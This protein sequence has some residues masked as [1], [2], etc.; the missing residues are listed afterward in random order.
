[1]TASGIV[2]VVFLIYL[3]FVLTV[4]IVTSRRNRSLDT[5][6]LGGRK[7]GPWM[8]AISSTASSESAWVT[9]GTVGLA[10]KE[11]LAAGWF[12]PGCL[13]GYC[14][15]WYLVARRLRS[16]TIRLSAIT[17][18]D[19]LSAR[20]P[21]RARAIRLVASIIIFVCMMG[22]VAAQLTAAGKA[23]QS[24]FGW[25]FSLSVL[26]GSGVVILYTL[27]GGFMAVAWTD[28][29]Q[30]LLMMA[31]LV[32]LPIVALIDVGGVS[33]LLARLSE[34]DPNLITL[35]GGREGF[36]LLGFVVGLLGIGFGYPGQP[37]VINRYMAAKDS[38]TLRR[39]R[40]IAICWG[41]VVY[42]GAVLLGLCGRIFFPEIGDPEQVFP[43]M[44]MRLVPPVIT[45]VMLAAVMSAIM[46][47]ADSQLLVASS[48]IA[49]DLVEKLWKTRLDPK[50]LVVISRLAVL[51][52]GGCSILFALSEARVV[53]WF[54]LFAW[55]GLGASFGPVIVW[56]LFSKREV[57]G[58]AVLAGMIVGF[59]VTVIWKQT[60]LSDTI[61][62]LVPAFVLAFVVVGLFSKKPKMA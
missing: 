25:D 52:L 57:T 51:V 17:V 10:Y 2:F 3:I 1:M 30:G 60:G 41:V 23:F 6:F 18:P 7:L 22:Y 4:G 28:L 53:F 48:T 8:T 5:F 27:L 31:S 33:P 45:G 16:E 36:G 49:H 9:L 38:V 47:T 55:S 12:I 62:E 56:L 32:V 15:N 11:G 37:H 39:G 61:Y 59:G 14:A 43:Q 20:C 34:I 42:Y 54:V 19:F 50:R 21:D 13:L 40:V 58:L 26:I 46:S 29:I 24:T 35:T 44:A